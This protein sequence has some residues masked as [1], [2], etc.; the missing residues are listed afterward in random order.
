M[1]KFVILVAAFGVALVLNA[2]GTSGESGETA[3]AISGQ[4]ADYDGPVG[5]L[6]AF[7][8]PTSELGVGTGSIDEEGTFAFSFKESLAGFT[9]N[10]IFPPGTCPDVSISDTEAKTLSV[11]LFSIV[12]DGSA[13]GTLSQSEGDV[14]S[15]AGI[16]IPAVLIS[17]TY[18]DRDV[19]VKGTCVVPLSRY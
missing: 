1:K 7:T 14:A 4:V 8:G 12:V 3:W 17:R 5:V 19:T 13:V 15:D 9:G 10:P 6:E 18:V 11:V 16:P 2:C